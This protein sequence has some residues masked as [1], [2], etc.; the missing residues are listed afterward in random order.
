MPRT[1]HDNSGRRQT[2]HGFT[3]IELLVVIAIIALL[4]G[5]LLPALGN[6]RRSARSLVCMTNMRQIAIAQVMYAD[7]N[8]GVL[9]D[10]GIDHGSV[11]EPASSWVTQLAPF[12]DGASPVV[13]SPLDQSP[14]WSFEMG[15]VSDGPTLAKILGAIEDIKQRETNDQARDA[16]LD[17]YFLSLPPTRWTSYGL[18]D[19]LTTKGIEYEDPEFGEVRPY[20]QLNR[21]QRPA[22][23]IQW[24]PMVEDDARN[25]GRPQFATSDHV[26][27]F[28]W[29]GRDDGAS[30]VAF[31]ASKQMEIASFQG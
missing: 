8:K 6:A 20:R 5:I 16:A 2:P 27:P 9:V 17:S 7:A 28:D 11:G 25:G 24:V 3:L 18:N 13:K 22:S 23:T 1:A 12:F 14:F 10:A 19:F 26:H 4:I 21:I 29:G 31:A 30:S 15:G